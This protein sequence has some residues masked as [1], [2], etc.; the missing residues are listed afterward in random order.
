MH[1]LKMLFVQIHIHWVSPI[2]SHNRAM[3]SGIFLAL[4]HALITNGEIILWKS[5]IDYKLTVS[6]AA[7]LNIIKTSQF[8][9]F[10]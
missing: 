9:Q 3:N 8:L 1:K 7:V 10:T 2:I 4:N 5:Q 6:M